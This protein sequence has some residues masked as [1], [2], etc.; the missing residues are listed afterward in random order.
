MNRTVVRYTT[1]AAISASFA[2][3]IVTVGSYLTLPPLG[4]PTLVVVGAV[5]STIGVYVADIEWI[6]LF[7]IWPLWVFIL[8]LGPTAALALGLLVGT[9]V[10][11]LAVP[12]LMKIGNTVDSLAS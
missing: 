7:S 3:L 12:V 10:S 11:L 6:I 1:A 8:V 4:Y 5:A 2:T 9:V